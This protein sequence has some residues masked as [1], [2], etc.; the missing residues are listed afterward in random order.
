MEIVGEDT[1]GGEIQRLSGELGLS[2]CVRFLG[3]LTQRQ[4][5]PR[6]EEADI[7]IV[8][9][10]HEA[11]PLVMLEAGVVGVPTVGTAVG[12][13][14]EWAPDAALAVPVSNPQALAAA[15]QDLIGDEDKRL[16]LA[17][18]AQSRAT[19]EDAD[20]TAQCVENLYRTLLT[21]RP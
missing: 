16:A 11:G 12:H 8:S 4:L 19:R 9:S 14:L 13:V 3:F 2:G 17:R 1:L 10:R 15:I 18:D 21:G 7:L 5:R 6:V 20:Y